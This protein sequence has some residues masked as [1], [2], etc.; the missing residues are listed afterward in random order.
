MKNIPPESI[1]LEHITV[2]Y[3]TY[4]KDNF[5]IFKTNIC[6]SR[7]LVTMAYVSARK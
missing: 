1:P 7:V 2:D 3:I 6:D 4:N 5:V